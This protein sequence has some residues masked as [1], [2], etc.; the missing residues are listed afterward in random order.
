M[1]HLAIVDLGSNSTRMVVE[2]INGDGTYQEVERVK[3]D[4]RL[5]EGMGSELKL[6]DFAINRVLKALFKFK[7]IYTK[8]PNI[9]IKAIATAAVRQA[10][11]QAEF[12]K[13]VKDKIGIDIQILSGDEE[14][15]YD[16]LGVWQTLSIND[17]LIVDTGGASVELILIRNAKKIGMISVPFGAVNLSEKFKLNDLPSAF[18]I[19]SA[20]RYVQN[21]YKT[22]PWLNEAK[23]VPIILLGGANRT[24][25]RMQYAKT[26]GT[27]QQNFH[28]F[29]MTSDDALDLFGQ[30]LSCNKD[31]RTKIPGLDTKRADIIL[32]GCIPILN[33]IVTLNT[34][35]IVFSESGVREGILVEY[36]NKQK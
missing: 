25:A 10:K 17:G 34:P 22:I 6:K 3:E 7:N 35:K 32:G 12:L 9:K 20:Q 16:Y 11:N 31:E 21:I 1:G 8:Y 23:D 19:F 14:A 5:S 33:L 36:L 29:E 13:E 26:K 24:L 28:G 18:L 4:T 2:K 27:L 15:Y 30:L